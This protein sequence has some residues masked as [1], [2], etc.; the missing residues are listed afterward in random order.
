MANALINIALHWLGSKVPTSLMRLEDISQVTVLLDAGAPDAEAAAEKVK[1][2]FAL[3]GIQLI[4]VPVLPKK[5]IRAYRNTQVLLSLVPGCDWRLEYVV[6]R[7]RACFKIGREQLPGEPF[8][9]VVSDPAGTHYP[10]TEV[11]ARMMELVEG[12]VGK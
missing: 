3:K 1:E 2:Y 8:D 12:L 7:S 9:L 5:C 10:Q 4:V 6:R 11:F